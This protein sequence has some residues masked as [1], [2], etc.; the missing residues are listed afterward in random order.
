MYITVH[1]TCHA[2]DQRS[3]TDSETKESQNVGFTLPPTLD[4]TTVR[5]E[6]VVKTLAKDAREAYGETKRNM[7]LGGRLPEGEEATD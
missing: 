6:D 2:H 3:L 7:L 1:I 4:E 5:W